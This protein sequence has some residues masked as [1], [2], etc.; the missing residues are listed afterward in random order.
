MAGL[1]AIFEEGRAD[2]DFLSARACAAAVEDRVFTEQC[3]DSCSFCREPSDPPIDTQRLHEVASLL[4]GLCAGRLRAACLA[5]EAEEDEAAARVAALEAELQ[6]LCAAARAPAQRNWL[7]FAREAL[8]KLGPPHRFAVLRCA[9]QD[10]Q[11][12]L[13]QQRQVLEKRLEDCLSSWLCATQGEEFLEEL[14]AELQDLQLGGRQWRQRLQETAT[15]LGDRGRRLSFAQQF[16]PAERELLRLQAELQHAQGTSKETQEA[17]LQHLRDE[18]AAL[19]K[20][21]EEAKAAASLPASAPGNAASAASSAA[22]S[23]SVPSD[24]TPS[25]ARSATGAAV[26][27]P[28]SAPPPPPPPK[29]GRGNSSFDARAAS[30]DTPEKLQRVA[31]VGDQIRGRPWFRQ[32]REAMGRCLDFGCGTGLLSFELKESCSHVTGLDASSGML[33]VMQEK[34][35]IAGLSSKMAATQGPLNVLG[36]FDTIV[37]LLCIH[38][39]RDCESQLCELAT[40][41]SPSGRIVVIDFEATENARLFHKK[42]ET[43]GDHYEHDGLQA[44]A[45]HGWLTSAGLQSVE[46]HRVPFEKARAEGW[47]D[48]GHKETFQI[49]AKV[50]QAKA[51]GPPPPKAKAKAPAPGPVPKLGALPPRSNGLVNINWKKLSALTDADYELNSDTFLSA[52]A[53]ASMPEL[54]PLRPGSAFEGTDVECMDD[55]QVQY[56]FRARPHPS[57]RPLRSTP[58]SSSSVRSV[59][60]EGQ[61]TSSASSTGPGRTAAVPGLPKQKLLILDEK[62]TRIAGLFLARQRI[63]TRSHGQSVTPEDIC[64]HILQCTVSQDEDGLQSLRDAVE[65]NFEAGNPVASFVQAEGVDALSRCEAEQEHRLMHQVCGIAGVSQRLRCLQIESSWDRDAAKCQKHLEVLQSGLEALS[66]RKEALQCFFRQVMNIGNQLN[67]AAGGVR[68]PHGFRLQSLDS[69]LQTRSPLRPQLSLL[70]LALAQMP[71]R[72]VNSLCEGLQATDALRA[73][74]LLGKSAGVQERCR[75]LIAQRAVLRELGA[76]VPSALSEDDVFQ[77]HL[78]EFLD[79]RRDKASR[80]A[81]L[82]LEVFR[83]YWELAVYLGDPDAVFPPPSKDSD[84]PQDIFLFFHGFIEALERA[85]VEITRMRLREEIEAS[86]EGGQEAAARVVEK[87]ALESGLPASMVR[88]TLPLPERETKADSV[89]MTPPTSP[90]RGVR[91]VA[92]PCRALKGMSPKTAS[93]RAV[94][95]LKKLSCS[96]EADAQSDVSDWEPSPNEKPEPPEPEPRQGLCVVPRRRRVLPERPLP[97]TPS[98]SSR[99]SHASP[100]ASS[101]VSSP[102]TDASPAQRSP[103]SEGCSGRPSGASVAWSDRFGPEPSATG[104]LITTPRDSDDAARRRTFPTGGGAAQQNLLMNRFFEI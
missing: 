46:V 71:L 8:R 96:P 45:L 62:T 78:K 104:E 74:G 97:S 80:L 88:R 83:S 53:P 85:R 19:A 13:R 59:S 68:A 55:A 10:R 34:I 25:T 89:L 14:Q 90:S 92:S 93:A 51:R 21:E 20:A 37:S 73:Q 91:H 100:S 67:E 18:V 98:S 48:A 31:W 6:E 72:Q 57:Q 66:T 49:P 30:W 64:K 22:A 4:S 28:R 16:C 75:E 101:R 42:S 41:L 99:A 60:T 29:A 103:P 27:S 86:R 36:S 11:A 54:P 79:S 102:R 94:H 82:C 50:R 7:R 61:T 32:G 84:E 3:G 9:L 40:H 95:R 38:H 87:A 26:A 58:S 12:S 81:E 2:L 33:K 17:E 43:R 5:M 76:Q 1:K 70:H 63:Q 65:S 56:W 44:D 39:I 35:E 15:K 69:T 23:A 24:S 77:E 47:E 52:I